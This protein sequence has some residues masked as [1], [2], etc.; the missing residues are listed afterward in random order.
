MQFEETVT[1]DK[2]Q[3]YSYEFPANVEDFVKADRVDPF[4][5]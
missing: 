3:Y 5:R 4:R 2:R 1:G